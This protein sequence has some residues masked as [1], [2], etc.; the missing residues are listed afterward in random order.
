MP[1]ATRSQQPKLRYKSLQVL[2]ITLIRSST[3]CSRRQVSLFTLYDALG[4]ASALITQLGRAA[5]LA[6]AFIP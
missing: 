5:S 2:I 4:D 6:T 1:E 3:C